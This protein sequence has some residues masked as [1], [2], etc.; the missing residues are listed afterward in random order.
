MPVIF[1]ESN[2]KEY[3]EILIE[4]GLALIKEGG[5]K[6]VRIESVTKRV[7]LAKGTF[8]TFFPSKEEF[9]YQILIFYRDKAKK[10]FDELTA[11]GKLLE[12]EEARGFFIFLFSS[13]NNIYTFLN[14]EDYDFL[15]ARWPEEYSLN[16]KA[17]ETTSLWMLSKMNI[18]QDIEWKLMANYM[19]SITIVTMEKNLLHMDFYNETISLLIDSM[20]DYLYGKD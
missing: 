18:R 13:E 15:R 12:K 8:Y 19:K 3:R 20:L 1:N 5:F 17:D 16:P 4:S 7:G 6:N 11:N 2:F 9:V 14:Q 10:Y